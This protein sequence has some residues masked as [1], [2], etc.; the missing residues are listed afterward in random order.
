MTGIKWDD[1][2]LNYGSYVNITQGDLLMFG[3]KSALVILAPAE[4]DYITAD[5]LLKGYAGI[6][7]ND[8]D[9]QNYNSCMASIWSIITKFNLHGVQIVQVI[10]LIN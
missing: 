3:T 9:V 7:T 4:Q 10:H 8:N 1:T 2:V 6:G 5:K